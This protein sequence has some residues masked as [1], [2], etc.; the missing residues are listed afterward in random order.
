[1]L[2]IQPHWWA[3]GSAGALAA[4]LVLVSQQLVSRRRKLPRRIVLIRHGQ[5]EGNAT[6]DTKLAYRTTP[7]HQISLT[8]KGRSQALDAGKELKVGNMLCSRR[9]KR[10]L[11]FI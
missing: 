1:M 3:I 5:S 6:S 7:D 4:A 11:A 8:A 2:D 10:S 9:L